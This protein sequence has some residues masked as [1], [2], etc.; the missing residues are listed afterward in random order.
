M[1]TSVL[2]QCVEPLVDML[3]H[4]SSVASKFIL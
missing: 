2:K 1:F 3:K 4:F